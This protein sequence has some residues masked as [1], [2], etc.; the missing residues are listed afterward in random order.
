MKIDDSTIERISELAKL[1]PGPE[2]R[3]S[4]KEDLSKIL[5]FVEKLEETD[6]QGVEPL[7]HVLDEKGSPRPDE[8]RD[9]VEQQEALKNAPQRDSDYIKV[10]KFVRRDEGGG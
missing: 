5:A 8:I 7:R 10:P 4:L 2:E 1:R 6:T 9:E 3:E